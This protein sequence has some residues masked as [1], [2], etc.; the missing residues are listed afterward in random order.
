MG[1]DDFQSGVPVTSMTKF[2]KLDDP[3]KLDEYEQL[4]H[5]FQ[6]AMASYGWPLYA[7]NT[8]CACLKFLSNIKYKSRLN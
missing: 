7:Y 4:I 2:I 8:H 3:Q 1:I 6:Y 5:F